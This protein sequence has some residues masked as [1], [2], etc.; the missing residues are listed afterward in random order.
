MPHCQV[1]DKQEWS[2]N[3]DYM[4]VGYPTHVIICVLY[5][6]CDKTLEDPQRVFRYSSVN[7]NI[8]H[9]AVQLEH[10]DRFSKCVLLYWLYILYCSGQLEGMP[11]G[12]DCSYTVCTE[13]VLQWHCLL[14][15]VLCSTAVDCC[16]AFRHKL[17]DTE[18]SVASNTVRMGEPNIGHS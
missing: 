13:I 9:I 16:S 12:N 14:H 3:R 6:K 7:V 1:A 17:L 8:A 11:K 10:N 4:I 2:Y 18:R 5:S 15:N